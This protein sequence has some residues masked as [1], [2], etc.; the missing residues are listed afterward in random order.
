MEIKRSNIARIVPCSVVLLSASGKKEKDAMTATCMFVS[1]DPPY[2]VVSVSK[3]S[4]TNRLIE[5]SAEFVL[6]IASTDQV[7]LAKVLGATHGDR[8]D[9]FSK[10]KIGIEKS[11][12]IASPRLKGAYAFL[13]CRVITSYPV[14]KNVVYL[15]EVVAAQMDEKTVPLAWI[16]NRYY[17][18]KDPVG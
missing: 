6:N 11:Q 16:S 17:A 9:K 2:F 13:E 15:A 14:G 12:V 18:M 3:S 10:Y 7:K 1:E 4:F 5:E 8:V